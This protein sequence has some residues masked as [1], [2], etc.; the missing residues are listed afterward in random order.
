[1]QRWESHKIPRAFF[2]AVEM[3]LEVLVSPRS[4]LKHPEDF[5]LLA[6][7]F[8]SFAVPVHLFIP[9]LSG[10]IVIFTLIPAIPLMISLFAQREEA[11]EKALRRIRHFSFE[12]HKPVLYALSLFFLGATV[13][14]LVWQVVLPPHITASAFRDQIIEMNS[15]R[16]AI[17]GSFFDANHFSDL[18][19]NNAVVIGVMFLFSILY[20]IGALYVLLWNASVLATAIGSEIAANGVPGFFFT[21][22]GILPHGI[23]EIGGYI[24]AALG[25]GILSAAI[26]KGHYKRP[27]FRYVLLD[28]ALLAL[29]ALLL[30]AVGAA[31]ESTLA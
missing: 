19:V 10:S 7:L 31:I 17:S 12:Y 4:A 15:L 16:S 26:V 18:L 2:L 24:I 21:V 20:G 8:V 30:I 11:E 1:M 6:L 3:V 23:P 29:V 9:S 13:G 25:G 28:V 27:E 22:L 5:F 14:Y